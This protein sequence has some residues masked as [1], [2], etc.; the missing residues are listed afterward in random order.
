MSEEK[1]NKKGEWIFII[2]FF[3]V[4]FFVAIQPSYAQ[5]IWDGNAAKG[6]SAFGQL[7]IENGS[8]VTAINDS[9][10]GKIWKF[11]KPKGS[12]RCESS[13]LPNSLHAKEGDLWYFGWRY[14]LDMP[15]NFTTNAIFQWKAYPTQGSLQN[16]PVV[17]KTVNGKL[18]LMV[19]SIKPAGGYY[20]KYIW[21]TPTVVNQ[22]INVV[23]QIKVSR[24][25]TIGHLEFWYNGVKQNFMNGSLRYY[26]RT[27]DSDYTDPKWGIYGA[28]DIE[29]TNYVH[30]LKIA[31]TY[32]EADPM[33]TTDVY[34]HEKLPSS[35]EL[36]QNYPNPFNPSTAISY[37]ISASNHVQLKIYDILGREVAK[38]VDEEKQP[39]TYTVHFISQQTSIGRQL[40]SGIYIARL[41]VGNFSKTIKLILMK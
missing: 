38:L 14:K 35:F 39:G 10:Y 28:S 12:N 34:E 3:S 17:L 15:Q 25:S 37:Q 22:W 19:S 41:T 7:N 5:I 29:A 40:T 9:T 32:E 1:N 21:E 26:S 6:L 16:W 8:S 33:K 27:L 2:Y 23:L 31:G 11:N 20:G 24:D 4:L 36:Y 30:A 18:Y 13:H